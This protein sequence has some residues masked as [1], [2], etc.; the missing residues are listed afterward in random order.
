[1]SAQSDFAEMMEVLKA[2]LKDEFV[3]K[4]QFAHNKCLSEVQK[5]ERDKKI[6]PDIQELQK[7]L[8]EYKEFCDRV[9]Y[10]KISSFKLRP[11]IK[12][13]IE[14]YATRRGIANL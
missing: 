11:I 4:I 1:M 7:M 8:I 5:Q 3:Q 6:D 2:L 13:I 10:D 9:N 14:L 12:K